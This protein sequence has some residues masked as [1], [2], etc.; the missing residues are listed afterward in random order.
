[1]S[2]V[3]IFVTHVPSVLRAGT[4]GTAY[5]A[6]RAGTGGPARGWSIQPSAL[7]P[8]PAASVGG[9]SAATPL[10]PNNEN[11]QCRGARRVERRGGGHRASGQEGQQSGSGLKD[12]QLKEMQTCK[13]G[14]VAPVLEDANVFSKKPYFR[15]TSCVIFIL[16][17]FKVR[18]QVI[19]F[20]I[21][22]MC[23]C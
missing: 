4:A 11:R 2:P 13:T 14:P 5:Q 6:E 21:V 7:S 15:L 17:K 8:H 12:S 9:K 18:V 22:W 16:G 19:L 1:M 10:Y 23:A 20:H 3:P